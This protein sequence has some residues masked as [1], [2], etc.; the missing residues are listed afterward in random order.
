MSTAWEVHPH[1]PLREVAPGLW[2]VTGD[3]PGL[4]LKRNM[5]VVRLSDPGSSDGRLLLH[6][7]IAMDDARMAEL[8]ALGKPSVLV[9][10][11]GAHRIDIAR[12]HARYPDAKIVCPAG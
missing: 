1:G 11:N 6:S 8:E 2:E 4:P 10:P 12:Y 9:V 3:V 5:T 7:V